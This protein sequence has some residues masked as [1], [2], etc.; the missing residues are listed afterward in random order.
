[1]AEQKR[2]LSWT[3]DLSQEKGGKRK[4]GFTLEKDVWGGAI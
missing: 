1:M 2:E 3:F 4:R